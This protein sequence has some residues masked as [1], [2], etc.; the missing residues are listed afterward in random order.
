MANTCIIF[1][2][3][4]SKEQPAMT[5]ADKIVSALLLALVVGVI[6]TMYSDL[7]LPQLAAI[8]QALSSPRS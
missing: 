1:E 6:G 7:V 5:T 4:T 2:T 3:H 8:T